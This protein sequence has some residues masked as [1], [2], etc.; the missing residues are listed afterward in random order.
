M[1]TLGKLSLGL[2]EYLDVASVK[3]YCPN[4]LQVEGKKEI[5]K[6]ITG[7]SACMELF[8][9]ARDMNADAIVV[10]H[11]I[12]W[13]TGEKTIRG[14]MKER[15]KFLLDND[16]SLLAYHLPLDRHP[17]VGNNVQI[18]H[19]LGLEQ[20]KP[21]GEYNGK[22]IGRSG[23]M[24][25][26]MSIER[27]MDNVRSTINSAARCHAFGPAELNHVAICSGGCQTLFH[28]AIKDG[29]DLFITGE[30]SEWIYHLARE[31]KVHY[32]AAGHHASERFGP[33]ALGEWIAENMDVEVDFV[34]IPNPL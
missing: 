15:V 34:D 18:A 3:D 32:V 22:S 23:Q 21:F 28:Q 27:F 8:T 33:I 9:A 2:F 24:P 26:A 16:I 17:E 12:L 5:G 1:V 4:G 25:E 19:T 13:D 20:L 29:A 7:V 10:H 6:V 14:S 11:G 30:D 31:E